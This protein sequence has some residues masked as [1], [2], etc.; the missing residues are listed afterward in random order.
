MGNKELLGS[1]DKCGDACTVTCRIVFMQV[2]RWPVDRQC[3]DARTPKQF[4]AAEERPASSSVRPGA[5]PVAVKPAEGRTV[6]EEDVR[7]QR[8]S[9]AY[10]G[11]HPAR[12][13]R[14]R[15]LVDPRRTYCLPT[16]GSGGPDVG[17]IEDVRVTQM[18]L[19]DSTA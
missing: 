7:A 19:K 13:A 16:D 6:D 14:A 10:W 18:E 17:S 12:V 1:E 2:L 4:S 8:Y 15:V 3:T 9:L 11:P 5:S